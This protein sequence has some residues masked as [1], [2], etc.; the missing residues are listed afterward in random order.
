MAR[1][2]ELR[3]KGRAP[4]KAGAERGRHGENEIKE[5]ETIKHTHTHTHNSHRT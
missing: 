3:G 4:E 1:K 5:K 2:K